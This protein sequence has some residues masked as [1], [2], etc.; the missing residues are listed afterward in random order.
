MRTARPRCTRG[1][2]P[3]GDERW[4][5]ST[6]GASPAVLEQA[7]AAAE[8]AGAPLIAADALVTRAQLARRGV[9]DE[10]PVELLARASERV[11]GGGEGVHIR[12]RAIR[13]RSAQLSEAGDPEGALAEAERGIT[14]AAE[15]GVTWSGFGL[16]LLLMKSW[17]LEATGR[18]DEVLADGLTAVYSPSRTARVLATVALGVLIEQGRSEASTLLARLRG[19]GDYFSELQLDLREGRLHL[20]DGRP[21]AA[22]A[23]ARQGL[24]RLEGEESN[25]EALLLMGLGVDACAESAESARFAGRQD[26]AAAHA[27]AARELADRASASLAQVALRGPL[28]ELWRLRIRAQVARTDGRD[29]GEAWLEVGSA[30]ERAGRVPEQLYALHREVAARLSRGDRG[31]RTRAAG[32]S[33]PV[34]GSPAGRRAGAAGAELVVPSREAADPGRRYRRGRRRRRP[35][36]AARS[37]RAPGTGFRR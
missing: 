24:A 1:P 10:D 2:W 8:S 21:Q 30:A 17:I 11:G 3:P 33:G 12:I 6:R 22:L 7:V 20:R 26:Q 23:V 5:G 25:T 16:D 27:A 18:W 29:E 35:G 4:C 32:G 9:V 34:T 31:D 19:A 15:A 37:G 13:Y 14:L 28:G 36:R